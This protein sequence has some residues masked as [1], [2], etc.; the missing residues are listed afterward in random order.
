MVRCCCMANHNLNFT[1]MEFSTDAIIIIVL[2]LQLVVAIVLIQIS[3]KRLEKKI[4]IH[5][6]A[7]IIKYQRE[8]MENR[9][10]DATEKLMAD[11]IH[12]ADTNHL[13]LD[14]STS[15]SLEVKREVPNYS[16]FNDLGI[17]PTDFDVKDKT[18]LCL[19]PFNNKYNT[20]Y[21]TI[22]HS[23]SYCGYECQ[24]TDDEKL[25]NNVNLRR[26]IIT[27]IIQAQAVVAVLDGRNPNV[28]YEIGIAHAIGKLVILLVKREKSSDLPE[29][30]K[31]NRLLIYRDEDDLYSQ[32]TTTLT[33][34]K[35]A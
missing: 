25:E 32:L 34:V 3:I 30:L 18:I 29:N 13:L 4:E 28:M 5:D 2:L 33:S 16:Y 10:Y 1:E 9:I 17:M 26:Y 19:M 35:Y 15:N 21:S 11:T 6:S 7:S 20:L 27:R 12:F 31:G 22:K 8:Q 24:R 23:C 14:A